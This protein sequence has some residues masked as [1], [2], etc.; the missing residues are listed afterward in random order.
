MSYVYVCWLLFLL[1]IV[2]F[3]SVPIAFVSC[4]CNNEWPQSRWLRT[5]EMRLLTAVEYRSPR[6]RRHPLWALGGTQFLVPSSPSLW[7]LWAFVGCTIPPSASIRLPLS[8]RIHRITF[9]VQVGNSEQA[10]L[11]KNLN[12]I[13]SAENFCTNKVIFTGIRVRTHRIFSF[14]GEGGH[15][16]AHY[17]YVL[18]ICKGS[19]YFREIN[20]L[21]MTCV[22]NFPVVFEFVQGVFVLPSSF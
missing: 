14:L 2:C 5:T 9:R 12:L 13:T 15:H 3:L 8:T 6:P 10:L 19:L 16:S 11:F 20:V 7:W 1:W 4:G 21:S 18:L 17:T 22:V